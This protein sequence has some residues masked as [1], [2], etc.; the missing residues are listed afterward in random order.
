[1][2]G[3]LPYSLTD[4]RDSLRREADGSVRLFRTVLPTKLAPQQVIRCFRDDPWPF[5][6]VGRWAGGG[7]L[8]GSEPVRV[9]DDHEDPFQVITELPLVEGVVQGTVGGG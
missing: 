6:L 1:M 2:Q 3:C 4:T 5:A 9:A 7:A 8:V